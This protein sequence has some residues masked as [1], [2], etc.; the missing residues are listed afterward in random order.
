[1][2]NTTYF[3]IAKNPW[4][5]EG[6]KPTDIPEAKF[7][8]RFALADLK[9]MFYGSNLMLVIRGLRRLGKTT[10][11]KQLIADVLQQKRYPQVK[12]STLWNLPN[13]ITT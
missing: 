2:L 6:F 9:R 12:I 3:D 13:N 1:M 10:L 8:P 11:I 7:V 5:E 4:W